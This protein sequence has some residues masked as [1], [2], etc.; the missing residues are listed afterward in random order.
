MALEAIEFKL[1]AI[2]F[3]LYS[4]GVPNLYIIKLPS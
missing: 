2:E 3:K 4:I 1:E